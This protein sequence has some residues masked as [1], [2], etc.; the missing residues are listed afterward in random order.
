MAEHR[1]HT[2]GPVDLEISIPSGDME[3]ET[4]DGEESVVVVEGSERLVAETVVEQ[5]GNRIFVQLRGKKPFGITIEIGGLFSFGSEKLRVRVSV[6]HGSAAK[7]QS[8]S[9]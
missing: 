1:F 5:I 2:P 7:L 8:A 4:V 3:I 9:A 6:P